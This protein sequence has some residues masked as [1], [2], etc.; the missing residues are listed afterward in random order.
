MVAGS[1]V[2][3]GGGLQSQNWVNDKPRG[4]KTWPGGPPGRK[5]LKKGF[6]NYWFRLS[7][8][9]NPLASPVRK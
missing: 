8:I 9:L 7:D 1:G 6:K 3:G 5:P 4:R 2:Q